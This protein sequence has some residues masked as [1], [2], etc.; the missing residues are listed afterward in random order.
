MV[1][2]LLFVA[3]L[4]I[5]FKMPPFIIVNLFFASPIVLF[6]IFLKR[7]NKLLKELT[8][9]EDNKTINKTFEVTLD[10]PKINLMKKSVIRIHLSY[11]YECYAI[12]FSDNKKNKYYY[13]LD[14]HR[15][16]DNLKFKLFKEKF[17]RKFRVQCYKNTSIIRTIEKDPHFVNSIIHKL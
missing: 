13:F 16:F 2:S 5:A 11:I 12:V 7:D 10:R 9:I 4:Y 8:S 15:L 17:P 14:E 1:Y 3:L 6:A